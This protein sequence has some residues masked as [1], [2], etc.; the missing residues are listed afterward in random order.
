MRSRRD[1]ADNQYV[2]VWADG[3]HFNTQAP[4][5]AHQIGELLIK[6]GT[7]LLQA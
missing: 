4:K 1:L 3:I 2:Y 7:P 5:Y 6:A